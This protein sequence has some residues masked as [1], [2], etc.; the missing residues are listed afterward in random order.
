MEGRNKINSG[1]SGYSELWWK[2]MEIG[3][4]NWSSE[5]CTANRIL[6]IAGQRSPL[7]CGSL[8]GK[9]AAEDPTNIALQQSW[10]SQQVIF[11]KTVKTYQAVKKSSTSSSWKARKHDQENSHWRSRFLTQ[12]TRTVTMASHW[13][14]FEF[15]LHLEGCHF[16]TFSNQAGKSWSSG[17]V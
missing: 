4:Q 3:Y 16:A 10:T 9:L 7:F 17:E 8:C 13:T 5:I 12:I 1:Y 15:D 6:R 2:S 11:I 14:R